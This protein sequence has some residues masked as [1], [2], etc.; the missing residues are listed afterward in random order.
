MLGQWDQA[1]SNFE[2][3]LKIDKGYG[4]AKD[5]LQWARDNLKA[6]KQGKN[7]K[8]KSPSWG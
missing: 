5:G 2:T 8:A 7:A 1:I 6:A 4:K 3:V